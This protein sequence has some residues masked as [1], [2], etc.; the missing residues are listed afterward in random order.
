M[1]TR[2][3]INASIEAFLLNK[4]H[5]YVLTNAD[6]S[7]LR[8]YDK[9]EDAGLNEKVVFDKVWSI[10]SKMKEA[11]TAEDAF[12]GNV[13]VTHGGSGKA[14]TSAPEGV[15]FHVM[16]N[17]Y[18]C[19]EICQALT[20]GRQSDNFMRY[21]F[22][23]IAEYF[24]LGGI[25]GLPQYDLVLSHAPETCRH[26][27]LDHDEV[28]AAYGRRDARAYYAVR[29]FAF[30]E[31]S[32]SLLVI[33]PREVAVKTHETIVELLFHIE[34]ATFDFDV[35]SEAGDEFILKYTRL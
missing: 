8:K 9:C 17:D 25:D 20:S 19:H 22:G 7:F 33:V 28:L 31:K 29:S 16:N 18:F 10:A 35:P 5:D 6:L 13:L 3:E 24:Y 21:D 34:G 15:S 32:G 23:T 26:A 27:E 30:V 4:P 11:N 2:E 12:Y 14:I 1:P